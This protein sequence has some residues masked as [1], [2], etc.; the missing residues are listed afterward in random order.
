MQSD[1]REYVAAVINFFWQ[2]L[3]QSH[4]VN[5]NSAKVMYEALTEAQSTAS[6]DL[7]PRPT[8]TPS[9]NYIIKEIVKIG[10]R[11]TSGDTSL[12]NMCRDQVAANYKTHIRA[13][14]W[15]L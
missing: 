5:E 13:A 3:A 9:I 12:Y 2:G 8:C 6:I 7:V 11:I 4:S 14:L 1:D 10:Q 15:G